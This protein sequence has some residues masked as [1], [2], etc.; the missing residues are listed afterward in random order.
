MSILHKNIS[1]PDLHEP[2][3]CS[4]ATSKSVY[5][6][7]GNGTGSWNRITG[8]GELYI[9]ST[10]TISVPAAVDATLNTNTDYVKVNATGMWTGG[11]QDGVNYDITAG[12]LVITRSGSY[13]LAKW[14]SHY[15]NGTTNRNLAFKYAVNGVLSDRK[16]ATSSYHS[17]EL[18]S[19]SA[20]GFVE[21]TEGD[22]ISLYVACTGAVTLTITDATFIVKGKFS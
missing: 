7:D 14:V 11:L 19:S 18:N 20:T 6:A 21:L 2:K 17:G 16:V 15:V 10:K 13:E 22:R 1:D 4:S 12:E 8:T 3:G 9:S 5:I